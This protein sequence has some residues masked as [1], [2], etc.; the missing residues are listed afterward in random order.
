MDSQG[1]AVQKMAPGGEYRL[2]VHLENAALSE[3]GS[4]Q[5]TLQG[6]TQHSNL[7]HSLSMSWA[8]ATGFVEPQGQMA[9]IPARSSFSSRS[10]TIHEW[11]FAFKLARLARAGIWGIRCQIAPWSIVASLSAEVDFDFL[12]RD[13]PSLS[14][15]VPAGQTASGSPSPL[16]LFVACNDDARLYLSSAGLMSGSGQGIPAS[17]II[18]DDDSDLYASPEKGLPPLMIGATPLPYLLVPAG[19]ERAVGLYSF[20]SCPPGTRDAS[21]FSGSL[22]V[23]L[24]PSSRSDELP[25]SIGSLSVQS[26]GASDLY[27]PTGSVT[28]KASISDDYAVSSLIFSLRVDSG[29]AISRQIAWTANGDYQCEFQIQANPGQQVVLTVEAVDIAGHRSTATKTAV[30]KEQGIAG[31]YVGDLSVW[32]ND[33]FDDLYDI[34]PS[35]PSDGWASIYAIVTSTSGVTL[36]YERR[37]NGLDFVFA[38]GSVPM[39]PVNSPNWP[40]MW[41][42]RIRVA[43]SEKVTYWVTTSEGQASTSKSFVALPDIWNDHYGFGLLESWGEQ[44]WSPEVV[45]DRLQEVEGSFVIPINTWGQSSTDPPRYFYPFE[46]RTGLWPP[47]FGGAMVMSGWYEQWRRAVEQRDPA[48][49]FYAMSWF[50]YHRTWRADSPPVPAPHSSEQWERVAKKLGRLIAT[51]PTWRAL[52]LD[53]EYASYHGVEGMVP[54]ASEW[55][56]NGDGV[57]DSTEF[58]AHMVSDILGTLRSF[59]ADT[60]YGGQPHLGYRWSSHVI[61]AD[62]RL[63]ASVN[64]FQHCDANGQATWYFTDHFD[65]SLYQPLFSAGVSACASDLATDYYLHRTMD[66]HGTATDWDL[67]FAEQVLYAYL[68]NPHYVTNWV[69]GG[70]D[71]PA[72]AGSPYSF[73]QEEKAFARKIASKW[74]YVPYLS[75]LEYAELPTGGS[76]PFG[77][78]TLGIKPA[79]FLPQTSNLY[80][81]LSKETGSMWQLAVSNFEFS[82]QTLRISIGSGLF[83]SYRCDTL[84][85]FDPSSPNSPW[86]YLTRSNNQLSLTV[87]AEDMKIVKL[88]VPFEMLG[89]PEREDGYTGEVLKKAKPP[90]ILSYDPK[91]NEISLIVYPGVSQFLKLYLPSGVSTGNIIVNGSAMVCALQ[92]PDLGSLSKTDD[93]TALVAY[94][95]ASGFKTPSDYVESCQKAD[96]YGPYGQSWSSFYHDAFGASAAALCGATIPSGLAEKISGALPSLAAVDS[97]GNEAANMGPWRLDISLT[98]LSLLGS[99][100]PDVK[101]LVEKDSSWRLD[102]VYHKFHALRLLGE[103]S[104]ASPTLAEVADALQRN[105]NADGGWES[106]P[107]GTRLSTL[108][109]FKPQRSCVWRTHHAAMILYWAGRGI[110][111]SAIDYLLSVQNADGGWG[112][113][114]GRESDMRETYWAVDLLYTAG[115]T[116]PLRTY[117]WVMMCQNSDGGFGDRPG[118][119][120]RLEPTY[121]ALEILR[122]MGMPTNPPVCRD[123]PE[124]PPWFE[125]QT[126]KVFKFKTQAFGGNYPGSR[127]L[128]GLAV[129]GAYEQGI[130]IISGKKGGDSLIDPMNA[131]AEAYGLPV[132]VAKGDEIYTFNLQ[133]NGYDPHDH[134]HSYV[135]SPSGGSPWSPYRGSNTMGNSFDDLVIYNRGFLANGVSAYSSTQD[136]YRAVDVLDAA[137][138]IGGYNGFVSGGTYLKFVADIVRDQPWL[139]KYAGRLVPLDEAD[140][141]HTF[142][143]G[144]YHAQ[145]VVG[146]FVARTGDWAGFMDAVRNGRVGYIHEDGTV[147]GSRWMVDFVRASGTRLLPAPNLLVE[148]IPKAAQGLWGRYPWETGTGLNVRLWGVFTEISIDGRVYIPVRVTA[149]ECAD[150]AGSVEKYFTDYYYVQ[151]DI[152]FGIHTV[153]VKHPGGKVRWIVDYG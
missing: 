82:A 152:T 3:I 22:S 93:V 42:A 131:F 40:N 108:S 14:F 34:Y 126:Y 146:L 1:K 52:V 48:G 68:L 9:L 110:P 134:S 45:L 8:S 62:G 59:R 137:V 17:S 11:V 106:N 36:H 88:G 65:S 79:W 89:F 43:P 141:H 109:D 85:A 117:D 71:G 2:F 27:G 96:G 99:S 114:R 37:Y 133:F 97:P 75:N 144:M 128:G 69:H 80:Y 21:T 66:R 10:Q 113:E 136:Y 51:D 119:D 143:G 115:R 91:K 16:G 135:T 74:N 101:E 120:S 5:I 4:V 147:Y 138:E 123:P 61:P 28:A 105:Q 94:V 130:S 124:P 47:E 145:H 125:D 84:V 55:D 31:L 95:D 78:R 39:T 13:P 86:V 111:Q 98:A 46:D 44:G 81:S 15:S 41:E 150:F 54:L 149:A 49:T 127:D 121:Y 140:N 112:Y 12:I 67:G 50:F 118:W 25:P 129:M 7:P 83:D 56:D 38:S 72:D 24:G 122:K 57:L 77:R 116:I 18:I 148:P 58:E 70:W 64:H 87:P 20:L 53:Q 104:T 32:E 29:A 142:E 103:T 19:P 30:V 33:H 151:T 76:R 107:L 60:W 132:F 153:E 35:F 100:L 90:E 73:D 139:E 102:V 23:V 92:T 63:A 6:P 26:T